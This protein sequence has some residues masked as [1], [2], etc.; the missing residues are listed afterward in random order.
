MF[1]LWR[2]RCNHDVALLIPTAAMRTTYCSVR[3]RKTPPFPL[4]LSVRIVFRGPKDPAAPRRARRS[5]K[6]RTL[7]APRRYVGYSPRVFLPLLP[8]STAV[9]RTRFAKASSPGALV[10]RASHGERTSARERERSYLQGHAIFSPFSI[11]PP[12]TGERAL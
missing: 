5:A 4:P 11:Y 7:L 10:S 3:A 9:A 6:S 2:T 8:S 12:P 1:V